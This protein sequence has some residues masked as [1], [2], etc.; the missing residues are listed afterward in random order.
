M[1]LFGANDT[2]GQW[3]AKQLKAMFESCGFTSKILCYI[4]DEGTNLENMTSVLKSM[5]SCEAFKYII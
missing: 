5:I 3:L 2:I 1:G 4:K